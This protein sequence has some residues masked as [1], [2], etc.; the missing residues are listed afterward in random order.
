MPPKRYATW[1]HFIFI[2]LIIILQLLL[3]ILPIKFYFILFGIFIPQI[4]PLITAVCVTH[5]IIIMFNRTFDWNNRSSN[6]IIKQKNMW[7]LH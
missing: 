2:V 3:E 1:Q 7:K 4:I 6:T 5:P